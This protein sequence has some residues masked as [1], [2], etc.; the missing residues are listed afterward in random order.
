MA[1]ECIDANTVTM[2]FDGELSPEERV[3]VQKHIHACDTCRTR[4]GELARVAAKT[5][6]AAATVALRPP[7]KRLTVGQRIDRYAVLEW[8]GEGGMG[9]VYGAYDPKLERRVAIKVL[10]AETERDKDAERLLREAQSLARVSHPNVVAVYDVGEHEG[11]IFIAMEHV[12]G[13]TMAEWLRREKPPWRTILA[14][15][16]DAARGLGAVHAAGIVHRDF[17]PNNVLFGDDGRVRVTDFGLARAITRPEE[18]TSS[19]EGSWGGTPAYVSPEQLRRGAVDARGDQYSFCVA[20]HEALHGELPVRGAG[21]LAGTGVPA[22]IRNAL[23]RGLSVDP[24]K[25]FESMDALVAE[26]SRDR[27]A[28]WLRSASVLAAAAGIAFGVVAYARAHQAIPAPCAG[29]D[30][31]LAGIWDEAR[32]QPIRAAFMAVGRSYAGDAWNETERALDAYKARW[33][34]MHTEICEATRVHGDQS[35][36]LMDLRIACLDARAREVRALTDVFASGNAKSIERSVQAVSALSRIDGCADVDAHRARVPA[37]SDPARRAELERLNTQVEQA[38]ALARAEDIPAAEK[39][40]RPLIEPTR[41]AGD[42][43][44][45]AKLHYILARAHSFRGEWALAEA[46]FFEATVAA[47]RAFDE[48]EKARAQAQLVYAISHQEGRA[49]EA[50][51]AGKLAGAILARLPKETGLRATL[52][53]NLGTIDERA[54]RYEESL[55]KYERALALREAETPDGYMVALGLANAANALM[56]MGQMPKALEYQR[57]AVD[58]YE[59]RLGPHAPFLGMALSNMALSERSL[60]LLDDAERHV[61]RAR[62]IYRDAYGAE[63]RQIWRTGGILADLLGD[64]GR[65]PEALAEAQNTL[66]M[67]ERIAPQDRDMINALNSVATVYL[68]MGRYAEA[69]EVEQRARALCERLGNPA[70]HTPDVL[71]L[72]GAAHLGL[73]QPRKA[74]D[75]LERSH[76]LRVA[77]KPDASELAETR[78]LLARALWDAGVDRRRAVTLAEQVRDA[79]GAMPHYER[80]RDAAVAWLESHA[81]TI[82]N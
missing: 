72:L 7:R 20:L 27:R 4:F 19:I 56:E 55:E 18:E 62:D 43:S 26:L 68:R 24:A 38:E 59:R 34:A 40:A 21:E 70:H 80:E 28:L 41:A 54:G 71:T 63:H 23:E 82:R 14:R 16:I 79:Y 75:P 33:V 50:E 11:H 64:L 46:E 9:V 51:R 66:A 42:G 65:Y 6:D 8:L 3:S 36:A 47:E 39:T 37:P 32:K 61:R 69:L 60:R 81:R 58:I 73:G 48:L 25:R 30:R 15:Y 52:E 76:T 13:G 44:L 78:M 12:R 1:A 5:T 29:A 31:K 67:A 10:R 17:K 45:E 53:N 2:W 57:R 74:L 49:A 22:R 77:A 35:E